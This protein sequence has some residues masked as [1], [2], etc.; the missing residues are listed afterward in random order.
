M[1]K[2]GYIVT[3]DGQFHADEVMGCAIVQAAHFGGAGGSTG[4]RPTVIRTRDPKEWA[5]FQ[6][7]GAVLLDV[8]GVYDPE[9]GRFDH[10]QRGGA[11]ERTSGEGAGIPYATAGLVWKEYGPAV[12]TRAG[13][14][15]SELERLV[16]LVDIRLI[17]A[18]DAADC[19]YTLRAPSTEG[20]A[21]RSPTQRSAGPPVRSMSLT[22]II[23]AMNLN[24][25][26]PGLPS[27]KDPGQQ[28]FDMALS[29]STMVLERI[30]RSVISA[31]RATSSLARH[32]AERQDKRVLVLPR[33]MPWADAARADPDVLFV[34]F[35]ETTGQKWM[36][37]CVAGEEQFSK[38]NPLPSS[39]AGQP[40]PKLAEL[41][42]VQD[43]VF[44][45]PGAFICGAVSKEGAIRLAEL[46]MT[47]VGT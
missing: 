2:V 9:Q 46:A 29:M 10:H 34:V 18:L 42:G 30:V 13:A 33:F 38:R 26:E 11:G 7:M 41:T 43:A 20:E 27:F 1:K 28:Q 16:Q 17:A 35:P 44:C 40:A 36:C 24:W 47:E 23:S 32:L 8:G 5:R 3:H 4:Y 12:L 22:G 15:P 21:P 39:W 37:Q 19:G 45:H 25:D 14:A 6:S 31:E